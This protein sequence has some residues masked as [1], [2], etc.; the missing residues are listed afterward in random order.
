[1]HNLE[2]SVKMM[3]DEVVKQKIIGLTGNKMM[4]PSLDLFKIIKKNR[5]IGL[6]L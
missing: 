3:H 1:M 4:I 2:F 6:K 5:E